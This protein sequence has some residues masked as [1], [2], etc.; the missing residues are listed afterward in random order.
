[1]IVRSLISVVTALIISSQLLV[2]GLSVA[3]MTSLITFD[4]ICL[5]TVVVVSAV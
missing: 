1:M 5:S 3:L 4:I 2:V